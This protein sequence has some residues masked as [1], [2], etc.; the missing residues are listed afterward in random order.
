MSKIEDSL[1][2]VQEAKIKILN[3][4]KE[5]NSEI[6]P[7]ELANGLVLADKINAPMDLP[8]FNNSSMD[9][10]AVVA[11]DTLGA[12][13]MNPVRLRVIE[14]IPAGYAPVKQLHPGETS[15]IM[16]GAPTPIG[17]NAVIPVE[18]TNFSKRYSE[19]DLPETVEIYREIRP[20]DY[21]RPKGQDL[22]KGT[23]LFEPGRILRP[24][25]LGLLSGL[26][27][28]EVN[29]HPPANIALISSGDEIIK[30][31]YKLKPGKIYDMNSVSIR[32]LLQ[33]FGANVIEFGITQDDYQDVYRTL[34]NTRESGVDLIVSTAGVSV[35]VYDYINRVLEDHGEIDFWRVNMRPGKPLLFGKYGKIPF[36]GLP[37]NPVSAFVS[38]RI[39]LK[40]VIYKFAGKDTSETYF[41]TILDEDMESDGR[42]S[43][44]RVSV[45]KKE[46]FFHANLC[47]HQ[48]SGNIYSLVCS[49]ALLI[50]PAG[51]K[52]LPKGSITKF[53]EI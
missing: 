36:V 22:S 10:F 47:H 45:T 30:P 28:S 8:P 18:S 6:F 49:N 15:R 38:S 33:S 23:A 29:V 21:I 32:A 34:E 26:G 13:A 41:D 39:F 20:G 4:I 42:E 2:S 52:S 7:L 50:M 44:L 11:E 48:G 3:Q 53:L 46:N 14:D 12:N 51:V 43:Y 37:G 27:L 24:Q 1:L 19:Q 40:S 16:T 9:G 5:K 25:D 35:G 31:G 17:A